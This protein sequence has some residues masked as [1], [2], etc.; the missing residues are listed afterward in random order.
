MLNEGRVYLGH[1]G[2]IPLYIHWSFLFLVLMAFNWSPPTSADGLTTSILI[3]AVL[4]SGIVLHE[5]GHGMAAKVQGAYGVT[6]T[7][8]GLG[9]LCSSVRDP[10]PRREIIILAAGPA[11]SAALSWGSVLALHLLDKNSPGLLYTANGDGTILW[12]FLA[13][14]A[15]LNWML[16]LFNILPIYPLD[17]GQITY[18]VALLV[19]KR[20][21]LAANFSLALACVGAFAYLWWRTDQFTHL[22]N[23]FM[24]S[25]ILVGW[26]LFNAFRALR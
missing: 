6:I 11:V 20:Q 24:Y 15:S 8:W 3:L 7:L 23:S 5:L 13:L 12:Q 10:L 26:L 17:G 16:F 14:S 4:L 25:L 9:G 19:T 18:Y 22:G 21:R 2:P 1:L